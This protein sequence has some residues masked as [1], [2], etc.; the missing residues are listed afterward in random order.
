M[1]VKLA[2]YLG[3]INTKFN[4]K[5]NRIF[6]HLFL[7]LFRCEIIYWCVWRS[8]RT[9]LPK[10][11]VLSSCMNK[12]RSYT[13]PLFIYLF[14]WGPFLVAGPALAVHRSHN[15]FRHTPHCRLNAPFTG[16]VERQAFRIELIILTFVDKGYFRSVFFS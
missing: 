5:L 1:H 6:Q 10:E 9:D 2:Q 3:E 8:S 14:I 4:R 16:L 11:Y 15:S 13:N 7:F 12:N